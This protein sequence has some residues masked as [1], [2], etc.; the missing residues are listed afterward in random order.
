MLLLMSARSSSVSSATP[1]GRHILI[2]ITAAILGGY[3]FIWGFIG[4]A[5][6]GLYALGMPFHDAEHLSSMLGFLLYLTVFLWAF[7]V[8]SLSRAWLVL[9]GGGVLMTILASLIQHWLV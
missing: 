9:V 1:S 3:V 2:R 5:L 7:A 4:L 6:A 8:R